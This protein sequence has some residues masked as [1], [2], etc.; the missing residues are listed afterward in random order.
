MTKHY[1]T[2][3][4]LPYDTDWETSQNYL[5]DEREM[6]EAVMVDVSKKAALVLCNPKPEAGWETNH[7]YADGQYR[8]CSEFTKGARSVWVWS[9]R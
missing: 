5:P 3:P 2:M 1:A 4:R 8:P 7:G 6:V 9:A